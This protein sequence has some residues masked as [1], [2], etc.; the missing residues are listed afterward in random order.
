MVP[1]L[2]VEDRVRDIDSRVSGAVFGVQ[3]SDVGLR[4]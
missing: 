4:V 3:I 1:E 2:R